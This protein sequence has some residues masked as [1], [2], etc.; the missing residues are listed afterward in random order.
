MA[1][2]EINTAGGIKGK[3]IQLIVEDGKCNGT[4]A[5]NAAQKLINVDG[6]KII[7]GDYCSGGTL[8]FVPIATAAK[9]A[10]F[11]PG[12]SSPKLTGISEYFV[13]NYPSDST[14]GS[15]L[16]NI[17]YMD[18][19]YKKVAFIQE[20]TDYALGVY[21][22][23][24]GTF[25]KLGGTITNES[26]PSDTTD[27]RSIVS[28]VKGQN[29]DAVFISVQTPAVASRIFTQMNQLGYKPRLLVSDTI[30]GDPVTMLANKVILEGALAAEFGVDPS[31]PKFSTM[32]AHYKEKFGS[33]VPYQSYAQ[34]YYD[35][36]YIV[37]A[38]IEAAGYDGTAVSSWFHEIKNWEG[39]SGSLTIG[40]NGDPVAG[41]RGEVIV[42]G[43]AQPYS[44]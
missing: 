25:L 3:N 17:A 21:N 37:A 2:N 23:F 5:A 32:L 20:Q 11:S 27:F 19:G 4:D 43:K 18:K 36:V 44:K 10:V 35:S 7:I 39:A 24:S 41:H 30:P 40:S 29:P 8:A 22:A 33:D 38:A 26:F 31:N 6:V 34:T 13:R 15:V 12:A 1:A 16:A 42:D 9:V 14:Q 28:K